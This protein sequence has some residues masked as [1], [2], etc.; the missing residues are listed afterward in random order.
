MAE[1]IS[2]D[3]VWA[4]PGRLFQHF[5]EDAIDWCHGRMWFVRVPLWIFLAYVGVKLFI[6]PAYWSVFNYLNL[7]IHEGGHLIF[8]S[9]GMFIGIAGG[10][11]LQ[12]FVPCASMLMFIKQRDYFG[13][14]V[15]YGWLSTNLYGVALYMY[16]ADKLQLQL[17][18]V[19]DANFI[20]HDW[21]WLFAKMGVLNHCE[22][23]AWIVRQMGLLSMLIALGLGAWLMWQMYK[24]PEAPKRKIV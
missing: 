22:K 15:C 2:L 6:D 8:K 7:G 5:K 19:G 4:L 21:N 24:H 12:C 16:D 9:L 11:F 1:K 20:I 17:V 14:A 3:D 10:S 23:F 18:T 13:L